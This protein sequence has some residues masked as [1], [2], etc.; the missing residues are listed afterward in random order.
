MV[1]NPT[2]SK[3]PDM[4]RQLASAMVAVK[5][6]CATLKL[7]EPDTMKDLKGPMNL[8]LNAFTFGKK[9]INVVILSARQPTFS[10]YGPQSRLVDGKLSRD[11]RCCGLT[12]LLQ[13]RAVPVLSDRTPPLKTREL[14]LLSVQAALPVVL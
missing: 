4:V 1:V 10:V 12:G 11:R 13:R 9:T 8:A 3:L 5:N 7:G 2:I 14:H 6:I